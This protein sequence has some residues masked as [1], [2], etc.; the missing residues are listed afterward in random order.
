MDKAKAQKF[1][2]A[3]LSGAA[4]LASFVFSLAAL[5]YLTELD[6]KILASI[7]AGTFCLLICYIAS[8]RPN[9]QSAR[10]LAA[11]GDRLLAVEEGD[12]TSP[13]PPL[14][15]ES[16]PAVAQAVDKLFAEVRAS[17]D[18]AHALGMFDP[19]TSLPN[20][21]HFRGE[22]D[23]LLATC[24][25]DC[26]ML[27]VDLDRFK[28][29]NDSLG[30]ARG[31]QLL[32]MVA[33]RLR[34]VVNLE[35]G[36]EDMPRPLVARLAGD[37]FTIFLAG[38]KPE[39]VEGIA[40]RVCRAIAEPF[41]LHGHS[42]DI[43]ASVGVA[44]APCHGDSVEK[45]MRAADIAMYQAKSLGGGRY[46]TFSSALAKRHE[47]KIATERA[48]TEAL[49]RGEFT[50]ALQPQMSLR[51]GEVTG[52]EA[53][54]RWNHPH[55]N[56]AKPSDFIE[57]AESCG[58]ITDIG[59]WVLGECAEILAQWQERGR[60]RRVAVNVSPRQLERGDFFERVRE[61]FEARSIPLSLVELEFTETAAMR[62]TEEQIAAMAALRADGATIAIDDFGTGYSN[63]AR[64]RSMPLDRVKLDPSLVVDI[65]RSEKARNIVQSVI[66]LI[67]AVGADIVAEA[68][69]NAAQA[70][71]LRTMGAQVVQGY[72]FAPPMNEDEFFTWLDNAENRKGPR[73][74]TLG[75]DSVA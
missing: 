65:D 44:L 46:V 15:Q 17:I 75:G 37:E 54:L 2:N 57:V 7:V 39:G 16:M 13:A 32:T 40:R 74:V 47:H 53:L 56:V 5:L 1:A 49:E 18:N 23:K 43:G 38:V 6:E 48:L 73:L 35:A 41:E 66:T 67:H 58:A 11:L 42:I 8:E 25:R 12:L 69:E 62:C 45:L 34:N 14:V 51:T 29:V 63:I 4:G 68:I 36:P 59:N 30:H 20:R 55:G 10:A 3:L 24:E 33:N 27:F 70:D 22:A 61:A 60:A 52:A 72:V 28:G 71:L 64:L 26:A 9:S 31:D 19:V 50:L 21:L